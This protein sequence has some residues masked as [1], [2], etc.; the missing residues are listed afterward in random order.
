M[1]MPT[2]AEFQVAPRTPWA[3]RMLCCCLYSDF[4]MRLDTWENTVLICF[5]VIHADHQTEAKSC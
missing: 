2:G 3:L 1:G 4:K 5:T